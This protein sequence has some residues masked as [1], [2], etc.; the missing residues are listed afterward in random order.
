MSH[1]RV[2]TNMVLQLLI[3]DHDGLSEL[4]RQNLLIRVPCFFLLFTERDRVLRRIC[5]TLF[6]LRYARDKA[7]LQSNEY[8]NAT[9]SPVYLYIYWSF[10]VASYEDLN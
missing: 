6:C 8:K 1:N 5:T 3:C 2:I 10:L 7:E 9:V 4:A